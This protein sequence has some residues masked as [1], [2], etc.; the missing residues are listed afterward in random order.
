MRE[1]GPVE[2]AFAMIERFE[3][4]VKLLKAELASFLPSGPPKTHMHI[5][6]PITSKKWAIKRSKAGRR[7]KKK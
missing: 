5:V 7:S 2:K 3:A 1:I 6:D 4:E